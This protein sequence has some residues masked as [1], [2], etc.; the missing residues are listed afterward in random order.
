M[1]L[2]PRTRAIFWGEDF[3]VFIV[4]LVS[5]GLFTATAI[6]RKKKLRE[7]YLIAM[8]IVLTI[9]AVTAALMSWR[10][11]RVHKAHTRATIPVYAAPPPAVAVR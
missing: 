10:W 8:P 1:P 9:Y 11:W 7:W 2:T 4:N 6:I 3:G 5:I